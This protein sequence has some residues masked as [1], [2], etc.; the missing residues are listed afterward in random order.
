MRTFT[1]ELDHIAGI[2]MEAVKPVLH[3]SI[4]HTNVKLRS[5]RLLCDDEQCWRKEVDNLCDSGIIT[6]R[7]ADSILFSGNKELRECIAAML[8]LNGE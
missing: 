3:H 4:F 6:R 8:A 1:E 7:E 2:C 5:Q